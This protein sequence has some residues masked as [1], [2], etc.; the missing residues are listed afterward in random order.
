MVA[1]AGCATTQQ[2][3]AR[4]RLVSARERATEQAVRVSHAN[5]A[6]A[7]S[8]TLVR[9]TAATAVVVRVHN[10]TGQTVSD[11]PIT[12]GIREPG[13][14]VRV[15]NGGTGLD[16]FLTHVPAVAPHGQLIW[17]FTARGRRAP[18]DSALVRIGY[19]SASAGSATVAAGSL[20]ATLPRIAVSLT[21]SPRHGAVQVAVRNLSGVPQY[22]LQVYAVA[23]RGAEYTAAARA[24]ITELDGGSARLLRLTLVGNPTRATV[25]LEAGPTEL[26]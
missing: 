19:P 16:Y 5:P 6:L 17:V 1:L 23:R 21:H 3:A 11:L 12:V 18:S 8:A 15:L 25:A 7:S 2:Q 4:L 9:S 13:G 22:G 26:R 20:P 14:T 10:L 24:T